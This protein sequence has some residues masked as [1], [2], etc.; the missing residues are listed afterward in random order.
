[1]I[2]NGSVNS[3]LSSVIEENKLVRNESKLSNNLKLG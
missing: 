3:V 1:M 2:Q